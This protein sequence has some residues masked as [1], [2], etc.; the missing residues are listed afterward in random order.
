MNSHRFLALLLL[1]CAATPSPLPAAEVRVAVASNFRNAARD[2]SLHFEQTS[3]MKVVLI[4]GPSGRH[5]A[6]IR[7]GAPFEA[8]LSADRARAERLEQEER[9]V[10]GSRFT[11]AL[12]RLVLWSKDAQRI[13]DGAAVLRAGDF[14]HLAV[15]NPRHAPYG[16]AAVEVL[17]RLGLLETLTPRLVRGE[18][19]EQAFQFVISGNAELGFVATSQ[20]AQSLWGQHGSRWDVPQE[21]YTPIVQQ[22]VLLR[23]DATA[24]AFLDY[25][26]SAAAQEIIRA[27]GYGLP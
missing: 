7:Q 21:L 16:Q 2:I 6:Q 17:S 5:F 8:F 10:P 25:L 22:A 1:L 13:D 3:G 9:I 14:R 12:G 20:L 24:H 15:A 26:R 4:F 18:N 19:V 23:D 27:H 11:Y